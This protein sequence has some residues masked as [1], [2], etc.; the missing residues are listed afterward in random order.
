MNP[1]DL[2]ITLNHAGDTPTS[3][4]D[5]NKQATKQ[6]LAAAQ[7]AGITAEPHPAKVPGYDHD[8]AIISVNGTLYLLQVRDNDVTPVPIETGPSAFVGIPAGTQ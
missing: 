8:A 5:W 4:W 6:W 2:I 7:Q 3:G 1:A